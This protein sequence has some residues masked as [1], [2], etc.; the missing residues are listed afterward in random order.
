MQERYSE[1]VKSTGKGK[2]IPRRLKLCA[3]ACADSFT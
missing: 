1:E 2:Y 3:M